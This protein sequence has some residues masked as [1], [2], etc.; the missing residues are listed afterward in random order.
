[1]LPRSDRRTAANQPKELP[2]KI[3]SDENRAEL[4]A[5]GNGNGNQ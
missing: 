4:W 2:A 1:M 5:V 3:F